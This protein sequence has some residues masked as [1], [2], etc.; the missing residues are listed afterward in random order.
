M[1]ISALT[2]RK[3]LFYPFHRYYIHLYEKALRSECGYKGSQPYWDWTLSLQ[4]PA[5]G[6]AGTASSFP[7]TPPRTSLPSHQPHQHPPP[8]KPNATGSWCVKQGPFKKGAFTVSI[9]PATINPNYYGNGLGYHPR[10]L[11]R[12]ISPTLAAHTRPTYVQYELSTCGDDFE[13]FGTVSEALNGSPTGGHY[14]WAG[15]PGLDPYAAAGD[16]V[17]YLHHAQM[18][19]AVGDVAGFE[20][21][22]ENEE[23]A[24]HGDY[25]Q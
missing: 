15:D 9:G 10:C 4:D 5:R 20:S 25:V 3:G 2:P 17:F 14:T 21:E 11:K 22:R 23:G 18:G 16:P 7:T 24:W 19:S 12:D 8:P 6:T 1:S 13:Y